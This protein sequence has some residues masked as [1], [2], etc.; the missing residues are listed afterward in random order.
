M[1]MLPLQ[2]GWRPSGTRWML[3]SNMTHS[4]K[5]KQVQ[6]S[7]TFLKAHAFF[8]LNYFQSCADNCSTENVAK[9]CWRDAEEWCIS[10]AS[11]SG[12]SSDDQLQKVMKVGSIYFRLYSAS[13]GSTRSII[14]SAYD[15]SLVSRASSLPQN[16]H[17][18]YCQVCC[19]AY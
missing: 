12:S 2:K 5:H 16:I 8:K 4:N 14:I 15:M 17:S 19:S 18:E 3:L 6:T 10:S 7:K 13:R 11:P 9:P 1:L